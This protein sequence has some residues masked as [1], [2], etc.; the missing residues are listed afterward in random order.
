MQ[1]DWSSLPA[2]TGNT[3]IRFPLPWNDH[4]IGYA[5]APP[6]NDEERKGLVP[7]PWTADR[8]VVRYG[9]G[10][11]SVQRYANDPRFNGVQFL[12]IDLPT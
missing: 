5:F 10:E 8:I 9:W 11:M 6:I 4:L 2:R 7:I 3:W 1:T 12:P